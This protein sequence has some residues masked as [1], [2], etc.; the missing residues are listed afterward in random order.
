MT[1]ICILVSHTKRIK[2][3]L[4]NI[5]KDFNYNNSV[6]KLSIDTLSIDLR[7]VDIFILESTLNPV[8]LEIPRDQGSI[9]PPMPKSLFQYEKTIG[10]ESPEYYKCLQNL[11]IDKHTLTSKFEFYI[12]PQLNKDKDKIEKVINIMNTILPNVK[13]SKIF[14]SDINTCVDTATE[15]VEKVKVF[16]EFKKHCQY[17]V[18]PC[19]HEVNDDVN[20]KCDGTSMFSFT[21]NENKM[22]YN[23]KLN[24]NLYKAFYG[25][26]ERGSMSHKMHCRNTSALSMII[27]YIN[28]PVNTYT[29]TIVGNYVDYNKTIK[30]KTPTIDKPTTSKN[31]QKLTQQQQDL[32]S[33]MNDPNMLENINFEDSS[34]SPPFQLA[35]A[36]SKRKSKRRYKSKN[37]SLKCPLYF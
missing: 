10:S 4:K 1:N 25:N 22:S 34:W 35:F 8:Q 14:I 29:P 33:E 20:G 26:S 16:K 11:K 31:E 7:V 23:N 17:I 18:I 24:W 2:C 28:S 19:L 13:V 37:K 27:F 12:I 6:I 9:L 5:Y 21:K 30:Y 32:L 15:L 36:G 3:L